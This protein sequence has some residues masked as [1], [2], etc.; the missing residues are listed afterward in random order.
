M[1]TNTTELMH[2]GERAQGNA[3]LHFHVTR[4]R[5]RVGHDVVVADPAVV[6][7][8]HVGHDPVPVTHTGRHPAALGSPG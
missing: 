8:V 4:E 6:G 1:P 3:V 2:D 7:N 5:R